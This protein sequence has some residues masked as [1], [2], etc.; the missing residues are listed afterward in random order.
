MS[1]SEP[2]SETFERHVIDNEGKKLTYYSEKSTKIN[3]SN[4]NLFINL[5]IFEILKNI[6]KTIINIID[7]LLDYKIKNLKDVLTVFSKDDRL[8]Y[9]GIIMIII[10]LCVYLIDLF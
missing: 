10:S 9:I 2:G 4:D 5:S 6:S 1:I 3:G 7:D 8:I